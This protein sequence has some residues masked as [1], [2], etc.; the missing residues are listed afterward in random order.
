MTRFFIRRILPVCLAALAALPLSGQT[1]VSELNLSD[2]TFVRQSFCRN[3]YNENK[4]MSR[5]NMEGT[6]LFLKNAANL[7]VAADS[8]DAVKQ[9]GNTLVFKGAGTTTVRVGAFHPYLC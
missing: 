4:V 1:P 2:V 6:D 7:V 3:F 9:D 8:G 5:I